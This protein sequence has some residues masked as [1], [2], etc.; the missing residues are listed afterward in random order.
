MR[1]SVRGRVEERR[2]S[3]MATNRF[4]QEPVASQQTP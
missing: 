3:L 1:T 2:D 4:K